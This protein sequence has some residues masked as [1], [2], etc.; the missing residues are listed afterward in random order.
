MFRLADGCA[1]VPTRCQWGFVIRASMCGR[2]CLDTGLF[3]V[4]RARGNKLEARLIRGFER[5]GQGGG[6]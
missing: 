6:R 2:Q 3:G 1:V 4:D 5:T